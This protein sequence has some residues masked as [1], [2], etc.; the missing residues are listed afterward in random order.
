MNEVTKPQ[1]PTKSQQE[2]KKFN[3]P[4]SLIPTIQQNL[5]TNLK[6]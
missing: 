4:T 3:K 6:T 2:T 5:N 1:A